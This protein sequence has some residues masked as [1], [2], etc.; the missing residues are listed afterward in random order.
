[1]KSLLLSFLLLATISLKAQVVIEPNPSY[2]NSGEKPLLDEWLDVES[3]DGRTEPATV[4]P[5]EKICFDKRMLVKARVPQGTGY[6]CIFVNT[7]IGLVAYTPFSKSMPFCELNTNDP[8]FNFNIIGLK[9]THFNYYNSEQH[10]VL[11]HHLLTNNTHR[12]GLVFSAI[13]SNQPIYRKNEQREFFG[14]VKAWEYKAMGATTSWWIFGK[15][16]PDK[17]VMQP[18]KYLG[19]FGVGYQ[20]T[21]QGLFIIL[22]LS[23]GGAYNYEAEVLQIE[24]VP[25]CFNSSPF[26]IV[27]ENEMADAVDNIQQAEENIDRRIAQNSTS[28]DPCKTLR[29]K[30]LKQQKK[31]ADITK[32]QIQSLQQGRQ[33][34]SMEQQ[35][36]REIET[37]QLMVDGAEEGICKKD[38]Q[39]ARSQSA[40]SRQRLVQEKTCLLQNK[41][42]ELQMLSRFTAIKTQY[43]NQPA[44]AIQAMVQ[45]R[46]ELTRQPCR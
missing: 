19:L 23:D 38:Q 35:V 1:M 32:Q 25:T 26:R 18:N 17:L 13:G 37:L 4:N 3:L 34:Q 7:K 2:S 28:D 21:E 6:T 22:Q 29:E 20:Y 30:T 5:A 12:Q 42:F 10:G 14:K 11:K 27:E 33:T 8:D 9:G 31:V 24:D 43:R 40:S 39:I 15:T 46:R 36:D 44:K 41:A 45:A 16:L